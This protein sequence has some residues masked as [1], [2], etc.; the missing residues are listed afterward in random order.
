MKSLSVCH[1]LD[2]A[3]LQKPGLEAVEKD[4]TGSFVDCTIRLSVLLRRDGKGPSEGLQTMASTAM[5]V[6]CEFQHMN[7]NVIS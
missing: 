4:F 6:L 1:R 2:K 3:K 5:S 7:S